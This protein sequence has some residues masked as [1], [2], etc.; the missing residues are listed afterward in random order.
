MLVRVRLD[1]RHPSQTLESNLP[2]SFWEEYRL[3]SGREVSH[4]EGEFLIHER[5]SSRLHT[6]VVRAMVAEKSLRAFRD[7]GI[8]LVS[9][10]YGSIALL[11]E[12]LG[13]DSALIREA[14]MAAIAAYSPLAFNESVGGSISMTAEVAGFPLASGKREVV[15]SGA[16]GVDM[17]PRTSADTW[18]NRL[19]LASTSLLVPVVLAL[20][21][22]FVALSA[23]MDSSR[24]VHEESENAKNRQL[25]VLKAQMGQN[26]TLSTALNDAAFRA[27]MNYSRQVRDESENAKNRQLEIL[28][29][30]MDQNTKLSVS[31]EQAVT[32]ATTLIKDLQQQLI[33]SSPRT[34]APGSPAKAAPENE[35]AKAQ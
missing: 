17:F 33:L 7:L 31:L 21:I 4:Q 18:T 22:C 9:I 13:I 2:T 15:T 30:Q 8:Q 27:V 20:F 1:F 5:F 35:T 11:L 28:K 14:A 25:E 10:E 3:R 26:A 12:V 16:V 29:S 6:H 24:Q 34:T 23:V 32:E 19:A